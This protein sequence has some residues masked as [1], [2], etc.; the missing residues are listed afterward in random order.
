MAAGK[1]TLP[2]GFFTG[3][4]PGGGNTYSY[5]AAGNSMATTPAGRATNVLGS[6]ASHGPSNGLAN[7]TAIANPAGEATAGVPTGG[8]FNSLF[9]PTGSAQSGP[10]QQFA[11][12]DQGLSETY[13]GSPQPMQQRGGMGNP[14]ADAARAALTPDQLSAMG[15]G[16]GRAAPHPFGRQFS[17]N[18]LMAQLLRSS[19]NGPQPGTG[20]GMGPTGDHQMPMQMAGVRQNQMTNHTPAMQ[21]QQALAMMLAR[22]QQGQGQPAAPNMGI[23]PVNPGTAG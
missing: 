19:N 2:P 12:T 18:Q 3:G 7:P 20:A 21:Q 13:P 15:V 22:Q 17:Q 1:P 8:G 5:N 10:G 6:N 9:W 16:Q 14:A 11:S 23:M 4:V